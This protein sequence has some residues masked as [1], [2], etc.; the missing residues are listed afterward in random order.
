VDRIIDLS[1]PEHAEL[2]RGDGAK[3]GGGFQNL[4]R[5]L[6]SQVTHHHYAG[7]SDTVKFPVGCR[8]VLKE[9]DLERIPR[10]AFDYKGGGWQGRL[11][12]IFG[13]TLGPNL[14]RQNAI[15]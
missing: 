10:Y 11:I 15:R 5:K 1:A 3:G 14:G 12:A 9:E 2:L 13:R 4:L 7:T 6:R 8:I